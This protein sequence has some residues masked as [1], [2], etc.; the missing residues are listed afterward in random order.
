MSAI[1]LRTALDDVYDPIR[2]DVQN[3]DGMAIDDL[4][5]LKEIVT[6]PKKNG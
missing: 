2:E 6:K 3:W 4:I 1:L 5:E